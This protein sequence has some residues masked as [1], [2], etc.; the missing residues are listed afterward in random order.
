MFALLNDARDTVLQYPLDIRRFF[1]K[2]MDMRYNSGLDVEAVTGGRVVP[3]QATAKPADSHT[4]R[5]RQVAPVKNGSIWEQAWT[6]EPLTA[7]EQTRKLNK[8]KLE[9]FEKVQARGN[10]LRNGSFSFGPGEI[11][12]NGNGKAL[13]AFYAAS[14]GART[15]PI[16]PDSNGIGRYRNATAPQVAALVNAVT[17]F[18]DSTYTREAALKNDIQA[19]ADFTELAAIDINAGWPT[20]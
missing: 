4:Y 14:P 11:D 12:L 1:K 19:A 3:V 8:A 16:G 17:S 20:P 9:L 15:V 13:I 18:V 6:T 7:Q 2:A 10:A 5:I